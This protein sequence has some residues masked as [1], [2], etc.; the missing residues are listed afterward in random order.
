M[1]R[2]LPGSAA[3][4]PFYAPQAQG[5]EISPEF[6][7]FAKLAYQC[8]GQCALFRDECPS[9]NPACKETPCVPTWYPLYQLKCR[10]MYQSTQCI[11]GQTGCTFMSILFAEDLWGGFLKFAYVG[12]NLKWLR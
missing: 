1:G 8:W 10:H 2:T 7:D 9:V 6:W 5:S 12:V 3:L 11:R 4:R